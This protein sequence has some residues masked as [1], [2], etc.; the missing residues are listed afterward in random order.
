MNVLRIEARPPAAPTAS[1]RARRLLAESRVAALEHLAALEAAI[2]VVRELSA[3]VLQGG[4]AYSVGVR[5]L[6]GQLSEDLLWRA[7]RLEALT[8]GERAGRLA[9]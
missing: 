3:E 8:A 2:Q 5:D 9:H 7:R 4:D 1:E 6:A